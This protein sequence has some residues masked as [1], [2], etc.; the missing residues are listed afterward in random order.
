VTVTRSLAAVQPWRSGQPGGA[1]I[2]C[3]LDV[4]FDAVRV[5]HRV[6]FDDAKITGVV[7]SADADQFV[8]R[9]RGASASGSRLRAEKGI[10][11]PDTVLPL[12]IV[13]HGDRELLDVAARCADVLA[14]SFVRHEDD[15]D[16]VRRHLE[17]LGGSDLGLVVKIETMAAL[18]RLPEILLRSMRTRRVGVMIA[19]GDLA[20]EAG[21]GPLAE[22]QEEILWL[23]EAAR[24]PVIWATEVLDK[25][26]RSGQPS[27]AEITDAAMAQR[28]ECVMLNKGPRVD[29]AIEVLDEILRRMSS[30]QRKKAALLSPL[31]VWG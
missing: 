4:A 28:A 26:A 11:L 23:C 14:L 3:T 5:G 21:Y 13:G 19:R 17:G 1:T 18:R 31:P 15:I 8:V 7:E 24:L 12:P 16:V 22:I 27:R 29:V 6:A 30:H 2:G 25:L 9:V 20:V 10:N